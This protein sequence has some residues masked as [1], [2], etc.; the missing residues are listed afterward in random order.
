[1]SEGTQDVDKNRTA[2]VGHLPGATAEDMAAAD[3]A[4]AI[5]KARAAGMCDK[6][7]SGALAEFGTKE[8]TK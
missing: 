1:M 4:A 8:R 2:R 7:I 5:H 3:V 6:C